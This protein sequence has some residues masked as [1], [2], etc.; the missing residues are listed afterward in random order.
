MYFFRRM[1]ILASA[2]ILMVMT[3]CEEEELSTLGEGVIGDEPFTTGSATYDVFA[4]NKQL[5]A[6]QTNRLPLYQLGTFDDPVYGKVKASITTQLRLPV[7]QTGSVVNTFGEFSQAIEDQADSDESISTIPENETVKEVFLYLPYQR[8]PANIQDRDRD[9]VDTT[10]DDDDTDPNSDSDN[11]GVSDAT[12]TANGTNPLDPDTDGDGI[13]DADDD[14]TVRNSFPRRVDLDSIYGDRTEPFRL[15]VERSTFFL[16]DLDPD[17][18]FEEAQEYFSTQEFSPTFTSDLLFEGDVQIS[19]EEILFFEEDDPDTEEDESTT[20][21]ERLSPGIRVP[22]DAQ[23]FQENLLDKEG[24]S[25][26]LSQANFSDFLRGVHI[27]TETIGDFDIMMLFDLSQANITVTYEYDDYNNNGT[28][29]NTD[30]DFV[31]QTERDFTLNFIL[32]N[33]GLITGN[34]VNTLVGEDLPPEILNELDTGENASRIYLR[35]G[36][37]IVADVALFDEDG[38]QDI[39]NEIKANNW[40]INEANLVFFVDRATLDNS[41]GDVVE[42]LRLYL[43]NAETNAP[44][45]NAF[46]EPDPTGGSL[47]SVFPNYD[48]VLQEENDRGIQ[49]TVRITEHINNIIVRDSANARLR[50][51]LSSNIL[52][53]SVREAMIESNGIDVPTMSTITPL[54]TVLFGSAD[55]VSEDK[56]LQL[57]LFYTEAN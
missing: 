16:R 7:S 37:G 17:S 33:N 2:G 45:Y 46:T 38:G 32:S 43:F 5:T 21:E 14:D 20:V 47:L 39:I 13:G 42:P 12:E 44:L 55:S 6:V 31:E 23:F 30:D 52:D 36:S 35:G 29:D 19:N 18:N 22:L 48:G 50:L 10:L 25:E 28:T 34:A 27:S 49:Y 56:K 9:G 54:G 8:P 1:M 15:K 11:D 51:A 4:F 3:S 41:G 57:Q 26:L 53:V 40:I 24:S